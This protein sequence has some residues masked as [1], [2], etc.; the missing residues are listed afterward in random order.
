MKTKSKVLAAALTAACAGV[1]CA[2]P[3]ANAAAGQAAGDYRTVG[4]GLAAA[5][6]MSVCVL[7]SAYA[8]A[9]IGAA[10]MGA[11]AEKPELLIRSLLF[12]ALAEGLAVLGFVIAT[13][14]LGK[15]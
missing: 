11:A 8:V 2:A 14:M 15:I 12:V 6:T 7:G 10:A 9:R 13:M 1:A 5:A 4:L 3:A